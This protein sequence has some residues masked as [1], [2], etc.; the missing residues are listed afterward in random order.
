MKCFKTVGFLAFMS[1]F[2][3]QTEVLL[4]LVQGNVHYH[5]FILKDTNFTKLCS[6]KSALTVNESFPGP[7]IRAQKGDTVYVNVYNEGRYG[8]TLHWHGIKQPRNPWFDGPERRYIV[9]A[10]PQR[11]E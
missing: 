2:L 5:E 3:L 10:C 9:L 8:V 6:T 11:L 7:I 1:I 4:G